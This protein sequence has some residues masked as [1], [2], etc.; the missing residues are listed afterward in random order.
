MSKPLATRFSLVLLIPLLCTHWGCGGD[1]KKLLLGDGGAIDQIRADNPFKTWCQRTALPGT[2]LT[3]RIP[4][5]FAKSVAGGT[6]L[7]PGAKAPFEIPNLKL[8]YEGHV[9]AAKDAAGNPTG[10]FTFYCYLSATEIGGTSRDPSNALKNWVEGAFGMSGL[11]W[12]DVQCR[13]EDGTGVEWQTLEVI[14]K[15]DHEAQPFC[16]I[17]K[18]GKQTRRSMKVRVVCYSRREGDTHVFIIHRVPVDV[19]KHIEFDEWGPMVPG[20]VLEGSAEAAAPA[21]KQTPT[22]TPEGT[23]AKPSEEAPKE[24]PEGT[25]TG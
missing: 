15:E 1:Y 8:T 21:P 16:Y 5:K 12:R 7:G 4:D 13:R 22:E 23:P 9:P 14:D 20:S 2:S 24:T 10:K 6:P 3:Y 17:D 11:E 25:E 19:Q 18:D